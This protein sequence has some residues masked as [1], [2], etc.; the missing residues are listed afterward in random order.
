MTAYAQASMLRVGQTASGFV[1][2]VEGHGTLAESPAFYEF[3]A[4]SLKAELGPS[5]VVLDLSNCDYLDSTFL[6]CLA[7]LHRKYN[8]AVPHRFLVA[9]SREKSQILLGPTRLNNLV[10]V[11]EVCPEPIGEVVELSRSILPGVDLGRH[12]M[13]C[14]RRLAELGGSRRRRFVQSPINW[15]ASSA[16]RPVTSS[17]RGTSTKSLDTDEMMSASRPTPHWVTWRRND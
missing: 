3:A 14:H 1:V 8:R 7:G 11:T 4:Q 10:D 16:K 6:G 2:F 9:A 13:E 12:V 15:L 5:T 17:R